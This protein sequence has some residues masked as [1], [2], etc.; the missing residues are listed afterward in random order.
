MT[1]W[2]KHLQ[3]INVMLANRSST[4][5]AER[6]SGRVTYAKKKI[7]SFAAPDLHVTRHATRAGK[8]SH[9]IVNGLNPG[10]SIQCGRPSEC[11]SEKTCWWQWMAFRQHERNHLQGQRL[12]LWKWLSLRLSKRHSLSPTLLFKSTR[13]TG[14]VETLPTLRSSI[15]IFHYVISHLL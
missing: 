11:S 4:I 7:R 2:R 14:L 10:V 6:G 1:L 15:C 8:K 9:Y 12:W 13:W 5:A 3:F